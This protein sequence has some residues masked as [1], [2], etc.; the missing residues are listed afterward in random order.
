M[1]FPYKYVPHKM[2]RM[3]EFIDFIFFEVWCK[4][5]GN[6]S[7]CLDLFDANADL[8]EVMKSFYY[9]DAKGADFFYGHVERIYGHFAAFTT[10]Q[11]DQF[12]E[13]YMANN[14]I[15]AACAKNSA[16]HLA[17]YTDIAPTHQTLGE[18]LAA[19]FKGLYSQQLLGLAVLKQKIGD[20]D[21]H[22]QHFMRA[23]DLG[24]CPFCGIGDIKG[25]HHSKREAYDHYLPKA[26]YPFNTI[27]FHNL[28][29]ACHECNST[30]KLTKDP[31]HS[32]A[33]RRRAFYPY[34]N[35]GASIEIIVNLR[36]ADID[37]LTP[38]DIQLEFGPTELNEE[39]ETWK[40]VYGIEERYK[41]MCCGKTVG[42]YWFEQALG[43]WCE[44]GNL[45]A[46]YLRTLTRQASRSPFADNNFLKKPFLEACQRVGLFSIRAEEKS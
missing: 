43:E 21:D 1:L 16:M 9:S 17:K 23:N 2:E 27:N 18:Q 3:Q 22:Y 5:A 46:D 24:K 38:D 7:F 19:F 39:I 25:V 4:A 15:E 20:I 13:W 29:P 33:G 31:L 8:H 26:L 10:A 34:A 42:K 45:P 40:D 6:G 35:S 14:N 11:I 36:T 30:Y 32:A 12:K 37:H 44:N 41:A 28:A